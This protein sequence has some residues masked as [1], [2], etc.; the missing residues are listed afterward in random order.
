V[1]WWI[2][3][4]ALTIIAERL[5]LIR[6]QRFSA[7]SSVFGAI[8]LLLLPIGPIVGL[9]QVDVGAR[10]LGAA[11]VLAPIWLVR[12]DIV[13]RTVRTEGSARFSAAGILT[14]YAWLIVTGAMLLLWNLE[15]GLHYD[16]VVH[17]FFIGFVFTA[18]IAHEPII[19]PAVTGLP[20]VYTPFL[21]LPL[22]LLDGALVA[23]VAAD[24]ADWSEVRRWA[25]MIQAVAITLFLLLSAASVLLGR[26]SSVRGK[27]LGKISPAGSTSPQT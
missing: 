1:P 4:L 2:A 24:L 21:Y 14:A 18:I 20:F 13:R 9:L 19:A 16:A 17:A 6:F 5:E 23:R 27:R 3:F 11:L 7:A 12:R 10:I 15:A 25:G 22:A 8:A 26:R